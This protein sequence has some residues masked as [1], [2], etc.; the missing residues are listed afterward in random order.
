M[1]SGRSEP[2]LRQPHGITVD[3]AGRVYVADVAARGVHVFDPEQGRYRFLTVTGHRGFRSPVGVALDGA[4]NVYVSDSELGEVVVLGANGRERR[5]IKA[6]LERPAGLA[7]DRRRGLL[8][9][10]DSKAHRIAVFDSVGTL[11]LAFGGRGSGEGEFNFP[12]NVVV[13]PDGTVLVTDALNFRIQAFSADGRYLRQFGHNGDAVGDLARPKGIALDSEGHVYVV[14]GLY[15]VVNVFDS[16]G[17]LLLSFGSAGHG[18]GEF[19]LA[20]GIAID[21]QDRVYVSDSYNGRVQVLQY[22]AEPR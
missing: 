13:A 4:G 21:R 6:G 11:H 18:R 1:L 20:T 16:T 12:T 5:R 9:V 17:R 15:D 19:W 10:A 3:S 22:L 7:Y 8:Y 2:R 14:E